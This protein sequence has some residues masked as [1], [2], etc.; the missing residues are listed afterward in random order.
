M[1][2]HSERGMPGRRRTARAGRGAGSQLDGE[3]RGIA[4]RDPAGCAAG[5]ARGE[6]H[7]WRG[8]RGQG[9]AEGAHAGHGTA[10][11]AHRA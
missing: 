1:K 10:G 9:T 5:G 11:C 6:W 2:S 8:T 7:S 3:G 4:Q